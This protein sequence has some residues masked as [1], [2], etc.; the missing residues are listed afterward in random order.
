[1]LCED[2]PSFLASSDTPRTLPSIAKILHKIGEA[3]ATGRA[4]QVRDRELCPRTQIELADDVGWVMLNGAMIDP[5]ATRAIWYVME[6]QV[7]GGAITATR[8]VA[9]RI[10]P[11]SEDRIGTV[12]R[13]DLAQELFDAFLRQS[14]PSGQKVMQTASRQAG[15]QP[16]GDEKRGEQRAPGTGSVP[17]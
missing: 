6:S 15:N 2:A 13:R 3:I 10:P 1:M 14:A 5:V 12:M 16:P 8:S 11:G 17:L 9:S 4:L 7:L